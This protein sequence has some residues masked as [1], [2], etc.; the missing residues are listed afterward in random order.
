MANVR[1][2][3]SKVLDFKNSEFIHMFLKYR[4][5]LTKLRITFVGERFHSMC[6]KS[7]MLARIEEQF[8]ITRTLK[9]ISQRA[10][11]RST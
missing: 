9:Y 4:V 11:V 6:G 7:R 5:N 1:V 8:G 2:M 10:R 3:R